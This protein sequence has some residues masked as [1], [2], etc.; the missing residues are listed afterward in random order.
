MKSQLGL[1]AAAELRGQAEMT[2]LLRGSECSYNREGVGGGGGGIIITL[3]VK[4]N[5]ARD[6]ASIKSSSSKLDMLYEKSEKIPSRITVC[7]LH[8]KLTIKLY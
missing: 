3:V 4:L 8:V 1:R 2:K 6:I 5:L 7:R